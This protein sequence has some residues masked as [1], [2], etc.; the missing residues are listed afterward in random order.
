[1]EKAIVTATTVGVLSERSP[2]SRV[3]LVPDSV[4][5][6]ARL[7]L[8]SLVES[9]AGAAAFYPDS[10]YVVQGATVASRAEVLEGSDVILSVAGP[11]PGDIA[12]LHEG[13]VVLGMLAPAQ[14]LELIEA[15]AAKG[16]TA[17][18]LEDLPRTVS[19]AQVMDVL[20]SQASI[21]G[22]KAVL[23]AASAFGRYFPLL[24]TAAGTS[25]PASVLILGAGVAGLSAIGTA[26]RLG[27]L[28]SAYDVRPASRAEVESLGARFLVL[29]SVESAA[30]SG[31][32][33]RALT[34]DEAK[35]QQDEL[36]GH[37]STFDVVIT[38]AQVPGRRPP[39]LVTAAAVG[40]MKPGSVLVDMAASSLGG[41]VEGSQPNQTVVTGS[42]VTVIGAPE[43]AS[44][45]P[46]A[47]SNALANNF[48]AVVGALI[49]DK[50]L[51]VDLDDEIHSGIVI[52]HG[53]SIVH[54]PTATL[55]ATRNA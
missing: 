25:K 53:G 28:V 18:S 52:T 41:N 30:G 19:R 10:A 44:S 12:L 15:L 35:A 13:Q 16:V 50:E 22:Y 1:M 21:A 17:V 39:L 3:A 8:S 34:A 32:Y 27:G 24:I 51:A 26:R 37:I 23:V 14:H 40:R 43:L 46:T 42:G 45:V 6:M 38:T 29:S 20:S 7:G 9:G 2:E 49:K 47:A 4:A 5:K 48:A 55:S 31:G 36:S 11:S 33:A 54:A